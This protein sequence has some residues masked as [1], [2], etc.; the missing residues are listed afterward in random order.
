MAAAHKQLV[1]G[2]VDD[3]HDRV[4]Q[5]RA[6]QTLHR[7][8]AQHERDDSHHRLPQAHRAGHGASSSNIVSELVFSARRNDRKALEGASATT[9]GDGT[10]HIRRRGV[11]AASASLD[12]LIGNPVQS[13]HTSSE[14]FTEYVHQKSNRV[15]MPHPNDRR[16]GV[17]PQVK[18]L[19]KLVAAA[20]ATTAKAHESDHPAV[21]ESSQSKLT[22]ALAKIRGQG[23]FNQLQAHALP[24]VGLPAFIGAKNP[25]MAFME[26][27]REMDGQQGKRR[28]HP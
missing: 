17:L 25:H 27:R 10:K 19:H 11:I 3:S 14:Q 6:G 9:Q 13:L 28:I 26:F 7:I 16:R 20:E 23:A 21:E 2:L 1:H 22:R 15:G 8:L 5:A 18:D 4:T 24:P 12:S